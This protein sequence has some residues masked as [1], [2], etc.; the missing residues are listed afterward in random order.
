M[1]PQPN[2]RDHPEIIEWMKKYS[3]AVQS[4]VDLNE[5]DPSNFLDEADKKETLQRLRDGVIHANQE[6]GKW[7]KHYGI[8]HGDLKSK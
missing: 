6:L 1:K 3:N 8:S 7:C 4:L 2:S 5:D